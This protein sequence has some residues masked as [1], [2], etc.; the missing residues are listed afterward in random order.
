VNADDAPLL[1]HFRI[2]HFNEKVRWALDHKRWP[3]RR[4]ALVP[5]LH[6]PGARLFSGQNR[7]PAIRIGGR[8][9]AGSDRI[10]EE[11]ERLRPEPPLYPRDSAGR[12]RALAIQKHFDEEVAPDLRRLFWECYVP[13][14]ALGAR[15]ACDGAGAATR[16]LWRALFPVLLPVF[17]ANL[18]LDH[19]T[20]ERA[21]RRLPEHFDRLEAEIGPSGYLVGDGFGLADLC[22]ASIMTALV[23]PPQFP[24]PLPVP[25][26]LELA[27]LRR[28]VEHRRGFRWVLDMYA[29]HR[30]PSAEMRP[31]A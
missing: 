16:L 4:R 29:R 9:I 26:P 21:H 8:V 14:P 13:H 7:L 2:S 25:W 12:E 23:R 5:G 24:Y 10:L 1:L 18:G 6:I 22:A 3:H 27:E 30:D 15:M 28:S 11:I 20:L 31:A 19:A 17:S